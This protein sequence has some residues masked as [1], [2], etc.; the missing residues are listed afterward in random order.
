VR[1]RHPATTLTLATALSQSVD[2]G[3]DAVGDIGAVDGVMAA[4]A[5]VDSGWSSKADARSK[6]SIAR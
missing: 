3:S 5:C 1:D 6:A 4:D 2:A